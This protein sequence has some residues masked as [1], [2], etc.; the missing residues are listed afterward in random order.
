[1]FELRQTENAHVSPGEHLFRTVSRHRTRDG[2]VRA[3]KCH[4]QRMKKRCGAGAWD[5]NHC[6]IDT[7]TGKTINY[8]EIYL[9]AT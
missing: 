2:A 9:Y 5:H 3:M 1:M 7:D 4:K 6:I 8:N